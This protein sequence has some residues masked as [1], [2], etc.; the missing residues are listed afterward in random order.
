MAPEQSSSSG[1]GASPVTKA[2]WWPCPNCLL[3]HQTRLPAEELDGDVV[4]VRCP[5]NGRAVKRPVVHPRPGGRG[6]L[7]R[8]GLFQ[9]MLRRLRGTAP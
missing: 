1:S 9:R 5:V 2:F 7:P 3:W 6:G 8:P 4:E